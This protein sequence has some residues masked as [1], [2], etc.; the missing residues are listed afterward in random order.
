MRGALTGDLTVWIETAHDVWLPHGLGG[1]PQ[2]ELHD[3]NAP[4]LERALQEIDEQPMLGLYGVNG[5]LAIVRGFRVVNMSD[6]EVIV[7]PY[8]ERP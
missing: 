3:L 8:V 6:C 1:P 4:R 2:A 5:K 7:P